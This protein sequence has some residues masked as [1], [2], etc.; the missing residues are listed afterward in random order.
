[1]C[2]MRQ[3]SGVSHADGNRESVAQRSRRQ[4]HARYA[5]RRVAAEIGA[6]LI[7]RGQ[8]LERE[9]TTFGEH[10]I[11]TRAGVALAENEPVAFRP[12]WISR[13]EAQRFS[14]QY[15]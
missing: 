10:G 11:E 3:S 7:V 12:G 15:G 14:I 1:M 8:L 2:A 6:I 9:K 4:L 5:V 13:V